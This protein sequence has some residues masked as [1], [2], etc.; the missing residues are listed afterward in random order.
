[1]ILFPVGSL[2]PRHVAVHVAFERHTLK[3]GLMF[4][5][6]GLKPPGYQAP[7]SYGSGGVNL[8]RP[9]RHLALERE[10][11]A[12]QPRVVRRLQHRRLRGRQPFQHLRVPRRRIRA[13]VRRRG[14][15]EAVETRAAGV[16]SRPRC[17]GASTKR[18]ERGVKL[19]VL[20]KGH[21]LVSPFVVVNANFETGFFIWIGS[22]VGRLCSRRTRAGCRASQPR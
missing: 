1:V 19:V 2:L 14:W 11:G 21:K 18:C 15:G 3:P 17:S 12:V 6:K 9:H 4:K 13:A 16:R 5:G 22:R 8:H 7:F 10:R 20:K